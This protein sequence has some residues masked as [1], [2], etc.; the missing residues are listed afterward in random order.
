MLKLLHSAL[1]AILVIFV[2][3][4]G[5]WNE[6]YFCDKAVLL[7]IVMGLDVLFCMTRQLLNSKLDLRVSQRNNCIFWCKVNVFAFD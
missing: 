7:V 3:T 6:R 2:E 4:G 1:P 5:S